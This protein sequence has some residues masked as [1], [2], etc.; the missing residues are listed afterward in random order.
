[1]PLRADRSGH[2]RVLFDLSSDGGPYNVQASICSQR[3]F[4]GSAV[5]AVQKWV[6][7]PKIQ[8]GLPVTRTGLETL[9][10][11]RLTDENG[12]LIPE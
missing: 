1:M 7:R 4:E 5:R 11:F 8:D 10:R 2:C 6:Y 12:V 3:L 9:I